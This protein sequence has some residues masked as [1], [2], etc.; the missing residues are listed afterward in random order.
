MEIRPAAPADLPALLAIFDRARRFMAANGNPGQWTPA[1]PGA[2]LVAADI[3]RGDCYVCV[4]GGR[5]EGVFS[6]IFGPDPTY[7]R[8]E[9]GAWPDDAPYA[10]VHRLAS[11]GRAR[12]VGRFC[13]DWCARRAGTLR[14]DTHADNRIMQHLLQSAGFVRCGVIYTDDGSPRLAYE[15]LP[16]NI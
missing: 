14:A 11:A 12:G 6:L 1:Y 13:L 16:A 9:N 5:I 2:A 7:A 8:I 10:T 15:R 3:A 4:Q